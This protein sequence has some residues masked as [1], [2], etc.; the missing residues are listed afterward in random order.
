MWFKKKT[1]DA[2]AQQLV[3]EFEA[4]SEKDLQAALIK[5]A[6]FGKRLTNEA[7]SLRE[8][9]DYEAAIK[10]LHYSV[11]VC[12]YFPAASILGNTLIA[13]HNIEAGLQ[14]FEQI[15]GTLVE[16]RS[17][18]GIEIYANLAGYCK[19]S[20]LEKA[21][22]WIHK[23]RLYA[24]D[25]GDFESKNLVTS[26]L[27]IEEAYLEAEAGNIERAKTLLED[28][29]SVFPECPLA[30]KLRNCLVSTG[31]LNYYVLVLSGNLV[32][33]NTD[34]VG[35]VQIQLARGL[36]HELFSPYAIS[37]WA[38]AKLNGW[39]PPNLWTNSLCGEALSRFIPTVEVS[40][41]D[42]IRL[43]EHLRK[44][45]GGNNKHQKLI[46]ELDRLIS[47][48]SQGAFSASEVPK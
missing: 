45:P 19:R 40:Q 30:H 38:M 29:L 16:S 18:V 14:Y 6:L 4:I 2:A 5:S 13:S 36:E 43:S 35:K 20:N 11:D 44:V 21:R 27:D 34:V 22:E 26:A 48:T 10:Y 42:A 28:R 9:G 7:L 24:R 33:F 25:L 23:G 47:F 39:N 15:V 31:Q 32:L 37:L 1:N 46:E 8:L 12:K 3:R 41:A 17:P